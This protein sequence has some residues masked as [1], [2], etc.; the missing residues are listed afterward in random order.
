MADFLYL[1]FCIN[2][3]FHLRIEECD[4]YN[5]YY[6]F[7]KKSPQLPKFMRKGGYIFFSFKVHKSVYENVLRIDLSR[8]CFD[9]IKHNP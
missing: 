4:E 8:K 7:V 6:G 1:S 2:F 3:G 9:C 5:S